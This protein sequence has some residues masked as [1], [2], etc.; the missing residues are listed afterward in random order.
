MGPS[1]LLLAALLSGSAEAEEDPLRITFFDPGHKHEAFWQ[2]VREYGQGAADAHG[3]ELEVIF[4]ERKPG[5]MV[6]QVQ[7]VATRADPP[8][9]MVMVNEWRKGPAMLE[10]ANDYEVPA[11]LILN[12]LTQVQL[13][14]LK[15]PGEVLPAW[16]GGVGP[17]NAAAGKLVARTLLDE[18]RGTPACTKDAQGHIAMMALDG[19]LDTPAALRRR[20]GLLHEVEKYDD[21]LLVNHV[22]AK[23]NRKLAAKAT[24]KWLADNPETCVVWAAN[25]LMALGAAD[26]AK[27]LG[28]RP[29]EDIFIAG[30]N[31]SAE[32]LEAVAQG[33]MMA[34]V[35][36]HFVALGVAVAELAERHAEG[37]LDQPQEVE[38]WRMFAVVDRNELPFYTSWR[39]RGWSAVDLEA[40][41]D[42]LP[43]VPLDEE[44]PPVDEAAPEPEP[45]EAPETDASP[46]AEPASET[47]P[48]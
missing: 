25:D 7:H 21:V 8:D 18:V 40:L 38:R 11:F 46:G 9:V 20:E 10:I 34:T 44:E 27:A 14:K 36:G 45:V 5:R 22:E 15:G 6:K 23:W 12:P 3:V 1:V 41:A 13:A 4:A 28:R 42:G 16:I 2:L 33:D 48:D 29:G 19:H 43:W 26:A 39:T 24:T 37:T 47:E 31:G 17:D 32:G 30:V 35:A